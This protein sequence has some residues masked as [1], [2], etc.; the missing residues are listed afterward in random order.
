MSHK[1]LESLVHTNRSSK[2]HDH[3]RIRGKFGDDKDKLYSK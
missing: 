2:N 1:Q 3:I